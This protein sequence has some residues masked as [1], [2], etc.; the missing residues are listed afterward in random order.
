MSMEIQN[1]INEGADG[2]YGF[3]RTY[4][5]GIIVFDYNYAPDDK[6]R[7][8]SRY[9]PMDEGYVKIDPNA[10]PPYVEFRDRISSQ[11]NPQRRQTTIDEAKKVLPEGWTVKDYEPKSY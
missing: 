5:A 3:A 1:K 11:S 8:V 7:E 6:V 10:E 9:M 4:D 2:N